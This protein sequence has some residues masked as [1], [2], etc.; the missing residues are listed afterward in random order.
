MNDNNTQLKRKL[1]FW[2][3][4]ALG[5]G[6]TIG[7]GIFI[8]CGTV[9]KAAGS[10]QMAIIAWLVGGIIAIPQML[11]FAELST[12]YPQDGFAY[13]YF[14]K[15]G[16]KPLAFLYGWVEFFALETPANAILAM[17]SV[18]YIGIFFPV[19]KGVLAGKILAACLLLLFGFIHYRSVEGGA[20]FQVIITFAK[21]VPFVF[22]IGIG[23]FYFSGGN[24]TSTVSS[25][26]AP[27]AASLFAGV[28][29]TTWAYY[30]MSGIC[31][32]SG[33]FKNP[34]KTL[35]RS[36][37][38]TALFVM[39]LYTLVAV[40]VL[41]QLPYEKII[42][43][44]TPITDAVM[45]IPFLHGIAP[46]FIGIA[47]VI[48]ILGSLSAC[49]MFQPRL[50][51]IMSRDGLF[52]KIFGHY[53]KKF[54]TP[55]ASIAIQVALSILYVFA[56]DIASLLGYFT[57]V[58]QALNLMV[59]LTIFKCRKRPDYFPSFKCPAWPLMTLLA[60]TVF[61]WMI[62]GTLQWAAIPGIVAAGIVV[63]TGLPAYYYWSKKNK[64]DCISNK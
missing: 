39:T 58:S 17:A 61:G 36:L 3:A 7:S 19:F 56:T 20:A 28:S 62:W 37:I 18:T 45:T 11:I 21:I 2:T 15:A 55:D 13:V 54:E 51:Y 46:T 12:A 26:S 25:A 60:C 52:F 10:S 34:E 4:L 29:A 50:E 38:G 22:I 30:G 35:P 47:A 1:G 48:V 57:L 8:N 44:D 6:T 40:V 14:S 63:A 5:I 43:T 64:N 32:M 9:A 42:S 49:I 53:N 23:M 41:G 33:E 31:Y 24:Y 16:Y 59:C 27:I